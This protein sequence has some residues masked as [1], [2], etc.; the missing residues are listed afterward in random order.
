MNFL[1]LTYLFHARLQLLSLEENE[2]NVLV[3]LVSLKG[4]NRKI[5]FKL[6][7]KAEAPA[8]STAALSRNPR[9]RNYTCYQQALQLH[10]KL[11]YE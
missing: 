11:D 10:W 9:D 3:N 7:P 1:P 6:L 4:R 2:E 5:E 8:V